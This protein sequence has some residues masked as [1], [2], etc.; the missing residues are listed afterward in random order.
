MPAPERSPV[1]QATA[2]FPGPDGLT[3]RIRALTPLIAEHAAQAEA[4][5]RPV[6]EVIEALERSGVFKSFVPRR[7]GGYEIDNASFI[8]IG[9]AIG[10]ACT[11]TGW[12]TTFC[13]EHNWML[14][15]FPPE[16][17]QAIFAEL[18]YIIAP[19][20]ITPSGAAEKVDG[21][22]VV[23]GR[24]GWGTGVMH[25]NWV[26]LN[27]MVAGDGP[28]EPRLFLA[29]IEDIRVE[30]TWFAAG[31]EGT[32]SNDMVAEDLFI[33]EA[34]SE[35]LLRMMMGRGSGTALNDSPRFRH[36]MLPL[37]CV[38]AA[39]PAIGAAQAALALFRDRLG[40]RRL[41]ATRTP[42]AER[43][44]A[45]V[46]LGN[47]TVRVQAAETLVRAVGSA[48]DGW[49]QG[50]E[51]CPPEERARLRLQVAHAVQI[52]RDVVQDLMQASGA[53]A[54]MRS[55]PMQRI[56]RDL[57]TL[58]CHTVFDLDVGGE[59]YGRLLLGMDPASPV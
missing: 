22:F 32:G 43:Q 18:P 33:P 30:D 12:V 3:D 2:R 31:M 38:A 20:S 6:D 36:P 55:H 54:H 7:F 15:Q 58:S 45:Q 23:N 40:G 37:L 57:N 53:G 26:L 25:A 14:A 59:N 51:F 11:S 34:R 24:W 8:D 19:A 50:D 21:G 35:S 5:R 27:G 41:Y 42:Q 39:S 46:L 44:T 13:M 47:A 10:E 1:S 52:C 49:G 29:P 17:Q 48:L 28:P 4:D 9:I 16:T 56:V